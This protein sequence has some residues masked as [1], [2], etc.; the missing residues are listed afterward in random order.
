[1][2]GTFLNIVILGAFNVQSSKLIDMEISDSFFPTVNGT[3]GTMVSC[4]KTSSPL[5]AGGA[6]LWTA[7]MMGRRN[8]H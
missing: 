6:V 3:P 5:L 8:Q 1:M 4:E 2:S 7:D